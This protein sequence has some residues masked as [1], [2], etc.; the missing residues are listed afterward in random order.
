MAY[1]VLENTLHESYIKHLIQ[2]FDIM[3]PFE[4][5]L[6]PFF[7]VRGSDGSR[8]KILKHLDPDSFG[9]V[10]VVESVFEHTFDVGCVARAGKFGSHD[11]HCIRVSVVIQQRVYV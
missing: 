7:A 4:P 9:Y 3:T 10:I 5:N 8:C 11:V 2:G 1:Q 6:F